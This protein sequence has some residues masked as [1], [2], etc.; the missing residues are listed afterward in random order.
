M[1]LWSLGRVL[2]KFKPPTK[3]IFKHIESK[4]KGFHFRFLF[5]LCP[6][7]CE[8]FGFEAVLMGWESIHEK[9]MKFQAEI[10]FI[11]EILI[12]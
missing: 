8:W 9:L 10:K 4:L 6:F 3:F 5:L 7:F 12:I 1:G 2:S 11:Q